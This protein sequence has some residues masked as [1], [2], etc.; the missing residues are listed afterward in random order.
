[1]TKKYICEL[2]GDSCILEVKKD[3]STPPDCPYGET[4]Y[5]E[6][7]LMKEDEKMIEIECDLFKP[8]GKWYT[9]EK[10][11]IPNNTPDRN[12]P[13]VVRANRRVTDLIHV[14]KMRNNVPFLIPANEED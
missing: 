1:M 13:N 3:S 9:A 7:E 10:V 2:C 14:G 12:V 11:S 6:W 8:N 5:P 4:L